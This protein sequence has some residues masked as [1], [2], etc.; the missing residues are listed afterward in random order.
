MDKIRLEW[1][2]FDAIKDVITR[3]NSM[4]K[5]LSSGLTLLYLG[6]CEHLIAYMDAYR[7]IFESKNYYVCGS[8]DRIMLD[9]YIK[10][11]L[12]AEVEDPEDLA[13]WFW[14]GKSIKKYPHFSVI[15]N[16]LS[17]IELCK[18]FDRQDDNYSFFPGTKDKISEYG[19]FEKRYRETSNFIHPS[20]ESALEYYRRYN[21]TKQDKQMLKYSEENGA[22]PEFEIF[23]GRIL[24]QLSKIC[25]KILTKQKEEAKNV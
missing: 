20:K 21:W 14:D 23:A 6:F 1:R 7:L 16:N 25:C 5:D 2:T 10:S 12:L 19:W 24:E 22:K 4:I 17:D 11:R 9:L 3:N 8:I 15:G 18:Y 13:K